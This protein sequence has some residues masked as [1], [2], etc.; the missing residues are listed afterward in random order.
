MSLVPEECGFQ[1]VIG[2]PPN[3]RL[4]RASRSCNIK[5]LHA[6]FLHELLKKPRQASITRRMLRQVQARFAVLDSKF[7]RAF[8]PASQ[9]WRESKNHRGIRV[10]RVPLRALEVTCRRRF[11]ELV[12]RGYWTVFCLSAFGT[13]TAVRKVPANSD[14]Q[15]GTVCSCLPTGDDSFK[16]RSHFKTPPAARSA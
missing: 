8:A 10:P 4:L 14:I 3:I 6:V 9:R 11:Y 12:L 16:V 7:C 5:N 2:E 15:T 1:C 13:P